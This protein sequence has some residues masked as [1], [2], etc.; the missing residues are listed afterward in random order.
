MSKFIIEIETKIIPLYIELE[1]DEKPISFKTE[2]VS[3]SNEKQ[4]L[5][6]IEDSIIKKFLPPKDYKEFC[7]KYETLSDDFLQHTRKKITTLKSLR[8][9]KKRILPTYKFHPNLLNGFTEKELKEIMDTHF[10]IYP[11]LNIENFDSFLANKIDGWFIN[12]VMEVGV[13]N[14]GIYIYDMS[15]LDDKPKTISCVDARRILGINNEN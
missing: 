8:K 7:V 10:E 12:D 6:V 9:F 13:I 2:L 3:W 1:I 5:V 4:K 14:D 11:I 15:N